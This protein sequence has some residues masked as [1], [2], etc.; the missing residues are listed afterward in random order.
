M[1]KDQREAYK[2]E[3]AIYYDDGREERLLEFI[4]SHPNYKSMQGKP[5]IIMAAIDEYGHKH[6][7]LMNVGWEKGKIVAE[8]LIPELRPDFM[9]ELGGYV[10]YSALFF[11]S[12]LKRARGR[13][14]LSLEASPK[15]AAVA[16]ALVELAGLDDV[17]E[18][19]VGP[20]RDSLR[21]IRQT[22]P[23][24]AVDVLF[25]D[26]AKIHYVNDLKLC[27][28]LSLVRPGTTV[29][30][31]NVIW[32][33]VPEYRAYVKEPI[34]GKIYRMQQEQKAQMTS[35]E[36]PSKEISL[37][38]PYLTYDTTLIESWGPTGE[39]DGLEV[40]RCVKLESD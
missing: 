27:E 20:C 2:P 33:G 34:A 32:P 36:D 14:Y 9:I 15:F 11:G 30:A 16:A 13:K 39:P 12:A 26:H 40:S 25:I 8:K 7:F 17:V 21:Q 38:N 23:T 37:G 3:G 29:I 24:G 19:I 18:I 5:E 4:Q 6:D 22:Y 31:D 10:G 28:E 1:T 35:L